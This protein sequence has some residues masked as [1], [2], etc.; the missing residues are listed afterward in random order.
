MTLIACESTA[1]YTVHARE[2]TD[3]APIRCGGHS[4]PRPEALCGMEI[5]WDTELPLSAV[6]CRVCLRRIE[7]R[8]DART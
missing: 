1:A 4:T 7:E 8:G 5:A 3:A 6:R 2:V